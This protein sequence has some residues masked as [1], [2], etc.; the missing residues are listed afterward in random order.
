V[1]EI[2]RVSSLRRVY[3]PLGLQSATRQP[4]TFCHSILKIHGYYPNCILPYPSHTAI[5]QSFIPIRQLD[6][7]CIPPRQRHAGDLIVSHSAGKLSSTFSFYHFIFEDL[8][9]SR[10][11][12]FTGWL[13]LEDSLCCSG[14]R[15]Q[16]GSLAHSLTRCRKFRTC[17]LYFTLPFTHS[18]K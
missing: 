18:L 7:A 11:S 6:K 17:K 1:L 16:R 2:Q 4:F 5:Q 9:N 8:C 14:S 15:W 13:D 3:T 12:E 10:H